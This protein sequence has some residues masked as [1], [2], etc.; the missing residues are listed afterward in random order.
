[1]PTT[2]RTPTERDLPAIL[3]LTRANRSLLAELEPDFWRK[4][5]NADAL[6]AAFVT[7]QI[8]NESL[9]K[10]V[11]ERD[12]RVIGYAVSVNHPSGFYFI[13]DICLS[14]D[15]DWATEGTHLLGSIEERPAI[16][17][18]PHLDTLRVEAAL[19][20]GLEHIG[21]VRSLRFD[22]EPPLELD[23]ARIT[24]VMSLENLAPPPIHPYLPAMSPE[25]ISVIGDHRGGYAVISAPITPPPIY[26]PGGKPSVVDR[27]IGENRRALLMAA[28][29]FAQQRGDLGVILIVD[30]LDGELSAIADRLGAR[31]PVDILRWPEQRP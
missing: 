6:H 30:A 12:G 5:A 4:S 15:A 8:A 11:L 25:S 17:T 3:E 1:M 22:Q 13:D 21:M 9:I 7:Y 20:L 18:A 19:A 24:P 23:P 29:G 14:A 10:R 27:V 31:H 16:M 26:D 2:T 28:L